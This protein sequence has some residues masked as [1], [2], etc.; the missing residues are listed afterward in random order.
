M[1]GGSVAGLGVAAT[2]SL[3]VAVAGTAEGAG[4]FAGD[5][6]SLFPLGLTSG[7]SV[8][9]S[10]SVPIRAITSPT[11]TVVL[12]SNRISSSI[13]P[14]GAGISES[15][16]SVEISSRVSSCPMVSPTAAF[17]S[18]IV[19]STIDSPSLGMTT[20][21]IIY[22]P[23]SLATKMF[24]IKFRPQPWRFTCLLPATAHCRCHWSDP[25]T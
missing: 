15:T 25:D 8:T 24:V 12:G 7:F 9:C 4:A 16:L 5:F 20:S 1:L 10:P 17:H 14:A 2:A 22:Q 13:P 11:A 18:R 19:P 6:S 23:V 3:A 21:T